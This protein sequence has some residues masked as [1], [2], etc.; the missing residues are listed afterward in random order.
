MFFHPNFFKFWPFLVDFRTIFGSKI[1]PNLVMCV[2]PFFIPNFHH[3]CMHFNILNTKKNIKNHWFFNGFWWFSQ[4]AAAQIMDKITSTK[5]RFL[6]QKINEKSVKNQSK[7]DKKWNVKFISNFDQFFDHFGTNFGPFGPKLASKR[8][9]V[10]SK[11]DPGRVLGA[12]RSLPERPRT[13][14]E[15]S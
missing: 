2:H 9:Q 5:H 1:D 15:S 7:F 14:P 8:R 3:F 10:G 12:S 13:L 11:L 4:V 6:D